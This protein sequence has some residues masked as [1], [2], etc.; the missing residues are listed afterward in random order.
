MN[1]HFNDNF[2]IHKGTSSLFLVCTIY[3]FIEYNTY[4][5]FKIDSPWSRYGIDIKMSIP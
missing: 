1:K 5:I 4:V 3:V 2:M